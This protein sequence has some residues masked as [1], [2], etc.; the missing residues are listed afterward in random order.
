MR[1]SFGSC[2]WVKIRQTS[3]FSIKLT[4]FIVGGS[5][6]AVFLFARSGAPAPAATQPSTN[7]AASNTANEDVEELEMHGIGEGKTGV[8]LIE[9]GDFSSEASKAYQ[10]MMQQIM[11]KYGDQLRFI[12][13]DFRLSPMPLQWLPSELLTP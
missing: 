11:D 10:P 9:Y 6:L 2:W 13:R 7:S 4:I 1:L 5:F 8:V 3:G 12:Y